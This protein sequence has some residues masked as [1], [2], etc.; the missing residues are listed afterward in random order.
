MKE[1]IINELGVLVSEGYNLLDKFNLETIPSSLINQYQ[2]WYN[3]SMMSVKYLFPERLEEFIECYKINKRKTIT[4]LTYK[5]YDYLI[6]IEAP[7]PHN[8][9]EKTAA[10]AQ[11]AIQVNIL[12]SVKETIDSSLVNIE[13]LLE[14]E[15]FDNEL[16]SARHLLK[17]GYL[18]ASG[19]ICGVVIETHFSRIAKAHN[20]KIQKKDPTISDYNDK[21]KENSLYDT[22][23]W[24]F[25][26]SLG[27][28]RNLC[29][30]KKHREPT[31]IEI[32]DL[33]NGN[34]KILKTVN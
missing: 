21:F 31:D 12:D 7:W 8:F 14:A 1:K 30:H 3:K 26:Q 11:L 4:P 20:I 27:D 16:D 28:I 33:K 6:G 23:T 15:I 29:D 10:L 17:N 25:I 13:S 19:A 5:I 22:T 9:N 18:R 2:K 32:N 24:R 34:E